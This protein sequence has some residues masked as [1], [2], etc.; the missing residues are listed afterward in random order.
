MLQV[1]GRQR[2]EKLLSVEEIALRAVE[3]AR[4]CQNARKDQCWA[5]IKNAERCMILWVMIVK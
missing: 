4:S 3:G 5:A 1:L 2:C